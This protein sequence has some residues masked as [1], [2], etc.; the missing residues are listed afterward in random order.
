MSNLVSSSPTPRWCVALLLFLFV[1]SVFV[2]LTGCSTCKP[3]MVYES[4]EVKVPVLVPPPPIELPA[5]PEW[6][7][8]VADEDD[9]LEY[10]RAVAKDLLAAWAH[11]ADL[12]WRIVSHNTALK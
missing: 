4:V 10:I 3:E 12:E 2:F 5:T 8:G 6:E 9:Y 1:A 11:I 7:S